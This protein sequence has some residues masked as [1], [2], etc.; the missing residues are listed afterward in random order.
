MREVRHDWSGHRSFAQDPSWPRVELL[1]ELHGS[2]A[3]I[4]LP[5]QLL[6]VKADGFLLECEYEFPEGASHLVRFSLP[7]VELVLPSFVTHSRP[8]DRSYVTEFG[9]GGPAVSATTEG[10]QARAGDLI[11]LLAE[12]S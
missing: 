8:T 4:S 6:Q 7:G 11:R 10:W 1:E 3:A 2:L 12:S 9:F 5:I